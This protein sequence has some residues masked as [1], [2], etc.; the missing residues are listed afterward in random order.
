MINWDD[1][2]DV[3]IVGS[4]AGGMAAAIR[5]HD[6][7]MKVLVL[8]KN[9]TVGGTSAMSGGSVWI[10]CNHYMHQENLE[11]NQDDALLYLK[12]CVGDVTAEKKLLA[13]I[14]QAAVVIHY[15]SEKTHLQFQIT[16]GLPDYY[17]DYPGARLQGRTL[18]AVP[19]AANQLKSHLFQLHPPHPQELIFGMSFTAEEA[20]IL[21]KNEK[22][23]SWLFFSNFVKT[24]FKRMWFRTKSY[25]PRLCL[26]NAL[27]GR[28]FLSLIER[29]IPIWQQA[30]VCELIS[31]SNK[32]Q[33]VVVDYQG[34][35]IRIAAKKGVILAAGGFANNKIMRT[36]YQALAST[37]WTAAQKN[38][39]GE[40]ILMGVKLDADIALMDEAWWV[41]VTLLPGKAEPWLIVI[42]KGLPGSMIVNQ[43]GVRFTNESGPYIDVGKKMLQTHIPSYLIMDSACRKKY[44]LA[45]LLPGR[46]QPDYFWKKEYKD[47]W[48]IKASS[49]AELA[50]KLNINAATLLQT[51]AE[52][53][54][55][56]QMGKDPLFHRG[57]NAYDCY[58]GDPTVKP[59]PCLRALSSEGPYYAIPLF[60]GD[61]GTKGGLCTNEYAQVLNK[62]GDPIYNLYAVG[63][64]SASVMGLSYPGAGATLGPAIVFAYIAAEHAAKS[65]L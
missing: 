9:A 10:P 43:T 28:L 34:K 56:A 2:T 25:S 15:L 59:V 12:H 35:K 6:L 47:H 54:Q 21:F 38:D 44:P 22:K 40:A 5:A 55:G 46:L 13:Y 16:H 61:L 20:N 29:Q 64:S 58:Y 8:E 36:R 53:N 17:P 31:D 1:T 11:D 62:N 23:A 14:S 37:E 39:N 48:I 26:G 18:E 63:N 65:N 30:N 32:V 41:P 52:F 7:G 51:V 3:I 24:I 45:A 42:E 27:V 33:G 60:P 4:G 50:Q 57:E 49:L 19:F